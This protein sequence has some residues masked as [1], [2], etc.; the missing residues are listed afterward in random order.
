[1]LLS[2]KLSASQKL[3][4]IMKRNL[5]PRV[6]R[7]VQN[8]AED[9]ALCCYISGSL[10]GATPS[11]GGVSQFPRGREVLRTLQYGKFWNVFHNLFEVRGLNT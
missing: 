6:Q 1:M 4:T 3:A 2:N 9:L 8:T 10:P 5:W 7:L 11:Q